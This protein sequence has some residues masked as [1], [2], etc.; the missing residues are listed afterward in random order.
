[1]SITNWRSAKVMLI[2]MAA[3]L[4]F[5]L[6]M[7]LNAEL[8]I[9]QQLIASDLGEADDYGRAV[10]VFDSISLV[11]ARD[12][13]VVTGQGGA[14]YIFRELD[15]T[16][17]TVT[18]SVKLITSDGFRDQDFGGSVSVSGSTGLVGAAGDDLYGSFSGAAYL[19]RELDTA[20]GTVTQSAKLL[21]SDGFRE[22]QFGS[23]VCLVDDIGLV[24]A[25]GNASV[26]RG[27]GVAYVFRGLDSASG[28]VNESAKLVASDL[29]NQNESFGRV[30][31]LSGTTGLVVSFDSAYIFRGL[32]TATGT[33][34]ESVKLTRSNTLQDLNF[35]ITAS[36]SG[37]TCVIAAR[38]IVYVFNGLDTAS[39]TITESATLVGS[40]FS[41]N[42]RLSGTVS[43][44][45]DIAL[46]SASL[47][48][49]DAVCIFCGVDAVSGPIEESVKIFAT[50]GSQSGNFGEALG[51]NGDRFIVGNNGS[52]NDQVLTGTVSSLTTLDF[53]NSS[54][55]VEK[56]S[57]ESRVDWIVGENT[58]N[59]QLRLAEGDSAEVLSTGKAVLIGARAGSNENSL[60]IAGTLEANKVVVGDAS[61]LGNQLIIESTASHTIGE[62]TLFVD[63]E[64]LFEGDFTTFAQLASELG[65]SDL[66]YSDGESTE[67]VT[68]DNVRGLLSINYDSGTGFTSIA[69]I[70]PVLLGDLNLDGTVDFSDIS[71][72][73]IVLAAGGFQAEADIDQSGEVDFSDISPF[74]EILS[75][76]GL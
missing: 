51:I 24:G 58:S 70:S 34:N 73:I 50:N 61:S 66:F 13:F 29:E 42:D 31:S 1:M 16:A 15:T 41:S 76:F 38:N 74:I 9:A 17:G 44:S 39:G 69:A 8:V 3:C 64:I 5:S 53:G 21:A 27:P 37:D 32:D 43:L 71:P 14:A 65:A 56:L 63:N 60:V 49:G 22:Q 48:S 47:I 40:N 4:L 12:Q 45:G 7:S 46:A 6:F 59:N 26:L 62:I 25:P 55:S 68:A 36:L 75:S 23:T 52:F 28:V 18:E 72:F 2:R 20:A 35:G 33:I 11:G 57:F 10:S 54:V 19:F 67:L 30:V